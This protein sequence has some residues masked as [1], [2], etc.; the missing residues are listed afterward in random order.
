M[1]QGGMDR[2]IAGI[3]RWLERFQSSYRSG[4]IESALMD[5]ECARADLEDLRS[6]VWRS[7][8]AAR[9]PN[10]VRRTVVG[11]LSS[12][13]L[14]AVLAVP[15]PLSREEGLE[16]VSLRCEARAVAQEPERRAEMP[17]PAPAE[18]APEVPRAAKVERRPPSG[19]RTRSATAAPRPQRS[20]AV[21]PAPQE[22][23]AVPYDKMF[24]LLQTGARALRNE[25][26]AIR[27][28]RAQ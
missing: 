7:V 20:P 19:K 14:L 10:R 27:I 13:V 22:G 6:D 16:G 3:I 18:P 8:G 1:V 4:A 2:R 15:S 23:S 17:P 11:W 5:A 25:G 28:E 12:L 21:R 26:P 9:T 24:L